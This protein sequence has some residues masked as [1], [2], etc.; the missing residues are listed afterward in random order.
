MDKINT[1]LRNAGNKKAS[2][3]ML[4]S[5]VLFSMLP[6]ILDKSGASSS[7][8]TFGSGLNFGRAIG[9]LIFLLFCYYYLLADKNIIAAIIR[10]LG[11]KSLYYLVFG[12]FA[13][14]FFALS[15]KFIA[16]PVAA[17]LYETW[18]IFMVLLTAKIFQ[19][20]R[21]YRKVTA[22]NYLL[23]F[24]C[25]LG[26]AFIII[27]EIEDFRG[28]LHVSLERKIMYGIAL[29]L[30]AAIIAAVGR[31]H[32][33]KWG[34]TLREKLPAAYGGKYSDLQLELFCVVAGIV[35]AGFFNSALSLVIGFAHGEKLD[36]WVF[37]IGI[38]AGCLINA[39][40][41][42]FIRQ[43]NLITDNLTVNAISYL[44]PVFVLV[45]LGLFSLIEVPHVDFLIIGT[46]TII[47]A[48]L[49]LNFEASI[50]LAY[51]VLIIALLV[52][53]SVVYLHDGFPLTD[54][55]STVSVSATV[56][57]LILSFR[58]NRLVRRAT[59]EENTIV[60]LLH[61]IRGLANTGVIAK[62]RLNG[63]I[64]DLLYIGTHKTPDELYRTYNRLKEKLPDSIPTTHNQMLTEI[65]A[66]IDI[67]T[68]SKQQG[69]NFGELTALGFIGIIL[70]LSLLFFQPPGIVGWEGLLIDMSAFMLAAVVLF[71]FFNII[72]LQR[73][74]Y[75]HI[76]EEN[77]DSAKSGF[78]IVFRDA[79]NRLFEQSVSVI[80]YTV[81]ILAYGWLFWNK[82][83]AV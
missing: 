48:N 29:V 24:L 7:P 11:D 50:R 44:Q 9:S 73:D 43:A 62:D 34:I 19:I 61:N 37:C 53:G 30:I 76:F 45:W 12:N 55:A 33:L 36:M 69:V 15:I 22:L 25:F 28:I 38:A 8:F 27:S 70:V 31:A 20:D 35:I 51:K 58:M 23:I 77:E 47:A 65:R 16:I 1:N 83:L 13:Y 40:A 56:F 80:V 75:Q 63:I 10:R 26:F 49:L 42:I 74:R 64:R 67:L 71:L 3:Y 32:S 2:A 6:L 81:V 21:R 68:H 18:P 46:T 14:V 17:I 82:W 60:K 52:C 5:V 78:S 54:Y 41:S 66:D 4:M 39:A 79:T 57:I 59:D 72:D